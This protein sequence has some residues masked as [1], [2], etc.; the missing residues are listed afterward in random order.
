MPYLK[1][2]G[3]SIYY[4]VYGEGVPLI[5]IHSHGLSHQMFS[6]QIHYFRKHYKLILVDL[7]GN[8]RSGA[9]GVNNSHILQAQCEDLKLLLDQLEISNAVWVGV[10]DGG[11]LVQQFMELYPQYVSAIILSDS[12]SQNRSKGWVGKLASALHTASSVTSYLPNE[13]FTRSLKLTYYNW[14]FAYRVLRNEMVQKR[15]TEWIKQRAALKEV[16]LTPS[17]NQINVPVLCVVGD[18]SQTAI[19]RMQETVSFI[20]D[21]T[22]QIIEDSYDPSNLCQPMKFNEALRDFLELHKERLIL[23]SA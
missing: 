3:S 23:D 4:E 8:G 14:D 9:L 6:P 15:P 13:F 7:R 11:I 19:Q 5:F 20:P 21:A 22:L 16:D 12:Y 2:D 17:L 10:S 18:F 1:V